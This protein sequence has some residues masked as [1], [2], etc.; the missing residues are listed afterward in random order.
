M[1]LCVL[2]EAGKIQLQKN[3]RSRPGAFLAAIE[4][5]REG[6]VVACEC[7]FCWYWL[8]DVCRDE[9]IEFVLGHALWRWSIAR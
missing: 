6:L 7:V 9:N 8:A 5:F 3:I 4:P 1:Y 2:D